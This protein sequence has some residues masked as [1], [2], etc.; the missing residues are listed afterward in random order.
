MGPRIPPPIVML[1]AGACMWALD[2]WLPV[3]HWLERPWN[4]IG[5]I[6]GVLAVLTAGAAILRFRKAETTVNPMDL[7]KTTQL[8]TS[9]VFA[10]TRNPMYL[11]LTLLLT[12]WALWLGSLSPWVVPPLFVL[13]IT[14]V[15]IIPEEQALERLFG[16]AYADYRRRVP[17]WI[18]PPG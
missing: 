6:P 10:L 13:L 7:S 14:L 11:G 1:L 8:V 3:V 16:V 15:Q 18:G 5:L 17:R 2:H 4:R 9:G 12:G